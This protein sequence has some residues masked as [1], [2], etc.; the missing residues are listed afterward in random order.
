M[1]LLSEIEYELSKAGITTY[2]EVLQNAPLG[3]NPISQISANLFYF[4]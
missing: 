3:E 2:N 4:Y 1:E